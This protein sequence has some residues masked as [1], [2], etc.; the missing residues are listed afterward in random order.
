MVLVGVE[1]GATAA[2]YRAPA[3]ITRPDKMSGFNGISGHD[4]KI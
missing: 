4:L 3:P 1:F 2:I